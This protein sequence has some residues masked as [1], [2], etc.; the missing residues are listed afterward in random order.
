MLN[1]GLRLCD[2][3]DVDQGVIPS[4]M[5][6]RVYAGLG[7]RIIGEMTIPDDGDVKGFTQRVVLYTARRRENVDGA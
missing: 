6:Q 1:W 3:D 4:H 7:Y 5:G 2:L